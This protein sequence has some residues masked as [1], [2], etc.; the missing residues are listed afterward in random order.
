MFKNQK[1]FFKRKSTKK[2]IYDD[3]LLC[4]YVY[5]LLN[6]LNDRKSSIIKR[7]IEEINLEDDLIV[8]TLSKDLLNRVKERKEHLLTN[9]R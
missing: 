9:G 1:N 5:L 8:N 7:D 2:K 6:I 3:Y 4:I